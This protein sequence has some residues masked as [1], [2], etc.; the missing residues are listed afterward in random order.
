MSEFDS[1]ASELTVAPGL[2]RLLAPNPSPM[3]LDGTNTW[4]VGDPRVAPPIVIDPG[5]DL[6]EHR[7][8][9]L[10]C[11][12]GLSAVLIT[13]RHLDH[14]EGAPALAAAAG[15]PVYAV[16]PA[17]RIGTA[18]LRPGQRFVV[19]GWELTTRPTPGHTSD[20]TSFVLSAPGQP[21]RLLTGDT[22]LGRG[23]TVI[24]H[25]DGDLG[26]YL[27]SLELMAQLVDEFQ[28]SQILP[29]HG[30]VVDHPAALVRSYREHRWARLEQVRAAV[31]AGCRTPSE[32]VRQVYADVDPA[33]WPAAEQS[34]RAQLDY[35]AGL[36]T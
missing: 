10:A 24:T 14:T 13:H 35:L 25:P 6:A 1:A 34:V 4:L 16:D 5:P 31:G 8:A 29:G 17:W 21:T 2:L 7:D 30:P 26:A 33:V 15:C 3:T 32:V 28:I 20:S 11:S 9:I 19:G 36:E 12:G 23:T 18:A 22:M 27:T